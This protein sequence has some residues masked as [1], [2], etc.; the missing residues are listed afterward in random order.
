MHFL[1]ILCSTMLGIV[2]FII[3]TILSIWILLLLW[4]L[5]IIALPIAGLIYLIQIKEQKKKRK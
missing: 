2:A 5:I 1:E 4:P 3:I